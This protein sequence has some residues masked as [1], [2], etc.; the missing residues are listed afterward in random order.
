MRSLA[1]L[2]CPC[3]VA[4]VVHLWL[5]ANRT[6]FL[7]DLKDSD[8][9][10]SSREV[11]VGVLS[12]RHHYALRD[13]IRETW[14]GYIREHPQFRHR[15]AV[16]FIIGRHGCPIPEED[17]EDPYS[18]TLLNLTDPVNGQEVEVL[19]V[20]DA[21]V[22][23]PSEVSVISLDFKVLHPVVITRLGVFPDGPNLEFRGNVTVK[24]F[25]VD[26]EEAV[27]TA[28]FSPISAGASVNGVWYKPVEQ[29]ILPRGFEGTLVWESL[30][31]TDLMTANVSRVQL[32]NGGGV[33]KLSSVEEGTLPHRSA[34]GF[35]GLAGGF[36]FSIYDAKHILGFV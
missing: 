4:V 1:L 19:S 35:P 22:L 7:L 11:L 28:R 26:Q 17:R 12:A 29:F 3:V 21:S 10:P 31:S 20:P 30:D 14:L 24:L 15:V 2:L 34:L 32:N 5:V 16:K 36:T 23:V 9:Q 25:Q 27:V 6:A 13:A 8:R 33:L 18:C